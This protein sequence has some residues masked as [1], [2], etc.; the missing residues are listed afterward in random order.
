M[1]KNV[2]GKFDFVWQTYAAYLDWCRDWLAECAR[3]LPYGGVLYVF[4]SRTSTR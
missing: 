4:T 3:L 1:K 2:K